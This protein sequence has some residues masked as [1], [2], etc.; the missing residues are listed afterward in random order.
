[1]D[2]S[3]AFRRH[4][5]NGGQYRALESNR[6]L[7]RL[8]REIRILIDGTRQ[9]RPRDQARGIE[10]AVGFR[11]PFIEPRGNHQ[12]IRSSTAEQSA[13]SPPSGTI[14]TASVTSQGRKHRH[15]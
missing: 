7:D 13:T 12:T 6:D 4:R 1:M 11:E 3:K 10:S 15:G 14:E 5:K 9:F 8:W 2:V